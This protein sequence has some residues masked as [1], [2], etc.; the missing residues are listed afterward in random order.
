MKNWC[1]DSITQSRLAEVNLS[2]TISDLWVLRSIIYWWLK[3]KW[4]HPKNRIYLLSS[5]SKDNIHIVPTLP[6][7]SRLLVVGD[8]SYLR[9]WRESEGTGSI[10]ISTPFRLARN[11]SREITSEHV[12]Y[13][14]YWTRIGISTM[15]HCPRIW[16]HIH[17][18]MTFSF[19]VR[20]CRRWSLD[21]CRCCPFPKYFWFSFWHPWFDMC[22]L[23]IDPSPCGI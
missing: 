19:L 21:P 10:S 11:K 22:Q 14:L 15:G 2:R 1:L 17:G 4:L 7:L 3:F 20:R 12:V 18:R 6:H 13:A 9:P 16:I 23:I 5:T 8:L